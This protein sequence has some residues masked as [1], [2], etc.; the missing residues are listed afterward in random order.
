M[1]VDW[2][3]VLSE[4]I[5]GLITGVVIAAL[6]YVFIDRYTQRIAFAEK[7]SAYGFSNVSLER[8]SSREVSEMCAKADL[9]KIINV[10]GLHFLNENRLHLRNALARGC[11]VR[12]LCARPDSQFLTDIERMECNTCDS[13][14][15]PLREP[16]SLIGNE[17]RRMTSEYEQLGMKIR[18]FSSEYRLPYVIAHYPDGSERAWLTMTL[19]PYKST[20]SFVLRGHLEP[21]EVHSSEVNF[22]EMMETNF[23]TIWEHCSISTEDFRDELFFRGE[24]TNHGDELSPEN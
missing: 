6:G 20:R 23:N 4:T 22:I 18:Y 3:T 5:S 11:E 7:M 14:G 15:K 9:L 8:Q 10:S 2:T 1:I 21:D 16:G 19:P 13:T 24:A 12:F 17:V